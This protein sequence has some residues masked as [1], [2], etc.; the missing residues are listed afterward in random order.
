MRRAC[1]QAEKV[2]KD[3][4]ESRRISKTRE[5]MENPRGNGILRRWGEEGREDKDLNLV[6]QREK[7]N[8]GKSRKKEKGKARIRI[9]LIRVS[10]YGITV[11]R[12][13][14]PT[15]AHTKCL[16]LRTFSCPKPGSLGKQKISH[17]ALTQSFLG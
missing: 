16:I 14:S 6:T 10:G 13:P 11:L 17:C 12:P 15:A 2:M 1:E 4:K 8:E 9:A 5:W 3:K 7:V